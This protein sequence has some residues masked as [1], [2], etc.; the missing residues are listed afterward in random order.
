MKQ[1][2]LSQHINSPL[3]EKLIVDENINDEFFS[4]TSDDEENDGTILS[5]SALFQRIVKSDVDLANDEKE[6]IEP[7]VKSFLRKTGAR[8][9]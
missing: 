4:T 7:Y 2:R 3:S 8:F 9:K 5:S 6:I 1:A